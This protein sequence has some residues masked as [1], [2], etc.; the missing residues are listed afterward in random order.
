MYVKTFSKLISMENKDLC[1]LLGAGFSCAV[2]GMPTVKSVSESIKEALENDY[3]ITDEFKQLILNNPSIQ[4]WNYEHFSELIAHLRKVII[5]DEIATYFFDKKDDIHDHEHSMRRVEE[6]IYQ[7]LL[8]NLTNISTTDEHIRRRKDFDKLLA[9]LLEQDYTLHIFDL[10]HDL[11]IDSILSSKAEYENFFRRNEEGDYVLERVPVGSGMRNI[12]LLSYRTDLMRST[13]ETKIYHYKLH[14]SL[15]IPY[16]FGMPFGTD[17]AKRFIKGSHLAIIYT[18]ECEEGIADYGPEAMEVLFKAIKEARYKD[19]ND[20][21]F[22]FTASMLYQPNFKNQALTSDVLDYTPDCYAKFCKLGSAG[23]ALLSIGYGFRDS[24]INH[25]I[26]RHFDT[27]IYPNYAINH[28]AKI[29]FSSTEDIPLITQPL[30]KIEYSDIGV[31]QNN[32]GRKVLYSD[33]LFEE[34]LA[35]VK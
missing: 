3:L 24:H 9:K 20:A 28:C 21:E 34:F 19:E 22:L 27:S 31:M 13:T 16:L 26:L 23:A 12:Y 5:N 8:D 2:A 35:Q 15:N 11:V 14:A 10:N 29:L 32:L 30:S 1:I 33:R 18:A 25:A 7:T 4:P 6:T 17:E